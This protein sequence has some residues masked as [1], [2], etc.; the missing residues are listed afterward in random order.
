MER[1][2]NEINI[3]HRGRCTAD[4]TNLCTLIEKRQLHLNMKSH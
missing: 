2:N 3:H 1:E 4:F